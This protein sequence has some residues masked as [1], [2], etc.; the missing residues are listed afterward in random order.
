MMVNLFLFQ[1]GV[2]G[3]LRNQPPFDLAPGESGQ[4]ALPLVLHYLVTP[5]VKDGD[6]IEAHRMLGGAVRI[7]HEHCW[8]NRSD[9]AQIA[10]YSDVSDQIDQI[11]ITWQGLDEKD[12]YSLWSA[13]QTPY[14]L[15]AAF[16]VRVVL[17]DSRV[18]AKTPLPVLRRGS[19]DTGPQV[20]GATD[21]PFPTLTAAI[22]AGGEPAAVPGESVTVQGRLLSAGDPVT[23]RLSHPLLSPPV[24]VTPSPADVTD[25]A[26]AFTLPK[27]PKKVP[28]GL[29][30]VS[31]VHT[32]SDGVDH[33]TNEVPLAVAPTITSTMPMTVARGGDGSA[34]VTLGVTPQVRVEQQTLLLL[35]D[36]A[37]QAAALTQPSATVVFHIAD[38]EPG[39]YAARLRVAGVD[40][41]LIDRSTTPPSL[42]P[43]AIVTVT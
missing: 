10:P 18:S 34:V 5:F 11:R 13:F 29:Y 2:E 16:E 26:I 37:V 32:D 12:I 15:S 6:D 21:L 24:D 22:P 40:T 25:S 39:D 8:L 35:G 38:A 42:D 7:L 20:Q 31:V 3:N 28:A 36:R 27:K 33:V 19:A 17:I 4:P 43:D 23:V 41:R 14:R 30:S 9:L 1:A